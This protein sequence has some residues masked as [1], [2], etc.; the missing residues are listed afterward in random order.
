MKLAKFIN[1][2]PKMESKNL[3]SQYM[4]LIFDQIYDLIDVPNLSLFQVVNKIS[5]D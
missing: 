2:S 4:D 1:L 5:E 3:I